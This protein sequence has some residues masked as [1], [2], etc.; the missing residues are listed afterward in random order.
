MCSSMIGRDSGACF[1]LAEALQ[2][3]ARV[4][5]VLEV[6]LGRGGPKWQLKATGTARATKLQEKPLAQSGFIRRSR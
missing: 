4:P 1:E 3:S 6:F 2:A 5:W